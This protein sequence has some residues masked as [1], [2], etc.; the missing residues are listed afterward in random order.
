[1]GKNKMR[2][3]PVVAGE[4]AGVKKKEDFRCSKCG[5]IF[6]SQ[7]VN[8]FRAQSPLFGS[9]N[10]YLTVCRNCVEDL[11]EQ[12]YKELGDLVEAMRR[13]CMKFDVYWSRDLFDMATNRVS[14]NSFV[15]AYLS[16]ANTLKFL[17][18]TYD[19][20]IRE[21]ATEKSAA[22]KIAYEFPH[23]KI[24]VNNEDKDERE[25]AVPDPIREFWGDGLD[26]SFYL[27]LERRFKYWCGDKK[28]E[29]MDIS[30]CAVIRQICML[31]V[32]ISRDT[33]AGKSIDKS[34]NALNTLLGS[35]NLKPVQKQ[36]SEGSDA[37]MEATPFGMWIRKI[38][39]TRPIPEVDPE[40]E[41]VDGVVKYITVWFFGHLCKM[42]KI[43]NRYSQ[44]YE[45]E[46]AKF[47]V[48]EPEYEGEEEDSMF[49]GIFER[50][51]AAES[52]D[53]DG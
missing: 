36:Q 45:A 37:N 35:A 27:E 1:M 51:S 14:T 25:S 24:I 43:D 6:H 16:K 50:A 52:G 47:R 2:L 3:T 48:D 38:E 4:K 29:E 26:A 33:A 39:N 41:D 5:K 20:T 34:I 21:E 9:N 17:G 31:E 28:R 30:E 40:L 11:F 53:A 7:K 10:G 19:D 18:K 46:L 23:D 22:E 15:L 44:L 42:L 13:L 12:Y 49:E 8:F 32:T